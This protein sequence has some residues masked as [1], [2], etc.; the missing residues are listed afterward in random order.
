MHSHTV[1]TSGI[2][3]MGYPPICTTRV[4]ART[5]T[6][7]TPPEPYTQ[8]PILKLL[9]VV[10]VLVAVRFAWWTMMTELCFSVDDFILDFFSNRA[11]DTAS[12]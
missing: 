4:Q 7:R 5:C 2:P 9:C 6:S 12:E 3:G 10:L 11:A 8:K 1:R